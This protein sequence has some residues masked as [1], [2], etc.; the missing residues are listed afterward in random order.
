MAL[1]GATFVLV[2]TQML[3][4][5]NKD[6]NKLTDIPVCQAPGGGFAMVCTFRSNLCP[7]LPHFKLHKPSHHS[8][9]CPEEDMLTPDSP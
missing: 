9:V 8:S 3:T 7:F 6:K 2:C 5:E 1:E 4:A